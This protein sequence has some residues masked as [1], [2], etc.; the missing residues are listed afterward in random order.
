[1]CIRDS[2]AGVLWS[3]ASQLMIH[4]I[5]GPAQLPSAVRLNATVRYAG[6]LIGPAL[7]GALLLLF[8][9]STGIALNALIYL[10]MI[11]FLWKAPYGLKARGAELAPRARTLRGF[12]ELLAAF[13]EVSANPVLTSVTLL[14]ACVSFL[15]G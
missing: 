5:V 7:G 10:P 9:P 4:D 14:A 6:M 11:L 12:G 15:V 1:M 3:P 13:R 2:F 8:G